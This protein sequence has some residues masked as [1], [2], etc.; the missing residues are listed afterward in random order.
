MW[1]APRLSACVRCRD[2]GLRSRVAA[3]V[4]AGV[5]EETNRDS[6]ARPAQDEA[7]VPEEVARGLE[8]TVTQTA[9]ITG[10]EVSWTERRLVVCSTAH[11]RRQSAALEE[12]V[13]RAVNELTT[14]G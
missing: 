13:Q 8:Y 7:E 6:S 3:V 12:R 11:A 10:Q 1:P 2:A 4:A 14:F 5:G 9:T